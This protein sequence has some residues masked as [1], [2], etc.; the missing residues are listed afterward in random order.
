VSD[1]RSALR[2]TRRYT[3]SIDEVWA[4]LTEPESTARWLG[5]PTDGVARTVEPGRVL[6]LDWA[7]PGEAESLV[8]FELSAEGSGTLLILEH[9]RLDADVCMRYMTFWEPRLRRLGDGL[10]S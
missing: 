9:T 1:E 4:A 3:A 6:E 5:S 10:D 2:F 8:R 7:R